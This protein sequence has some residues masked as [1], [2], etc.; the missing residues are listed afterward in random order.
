MRR[1]WMAMAFVAAVA[2]VGGAVTGR[3]LAED[4]MGGM[5]QPQK[6]IDGHALVKALSGKWA[7]KSDSG[8]TGTTS[9]R[10][11]ANKTVL[12]QEYE[13]TGGMM[14]SF[15]GVGTFKI[16]DDGKAATLWWL[17]SHQPTPDEY[18][19][20]VTD[21]G[22]ELSEGEGA[23]K[24]TIKL[25]KKGEGFEWSITGSFGTMTDTYTKAK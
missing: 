14:G 6:T 17:S 22:Y 11:T 24:V 10:L 20:T 8:A 3:A 13:S 5:P 25:V 2:A 1:N 9:F 4:E 15:A 19:G 12:L 23:D 18:K 7:V 16:A 21:T